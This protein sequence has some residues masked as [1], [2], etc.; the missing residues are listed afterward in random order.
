MPQT[1][2]KT[3]R[4]IAGAIT[5]SRGMMEFHIDPESPAHIP[6]FNQDKTYLF[7]SRIRWSV[8]ARGEGGHVNGPRAGREHVWRRRCM[9]EGGGHSGVNHGR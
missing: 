1:I 9:G 3:S 8:G 2:T 4:D 7:L 5:S 6:E